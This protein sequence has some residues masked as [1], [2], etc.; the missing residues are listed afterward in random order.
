MTATDLKCTIA[1][2]AA[3][4]Q[5]GRSIAQTA[6]AGTIIYL[7]GELG[8][9]KTTFTRGFLRGLGYEGSVKS[10]TYTVVEPYELDKLTVYHFDLY[11]LTDPEE[12]ELIGM[13]DY[14]A[15]HAICIIEWP[16][17]GDSCLPA[18]DLICMIA[19]QQDQRA[20]TLLANSDIGKRI[21]RQL[22]EQDF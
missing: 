21:I 17:K 14:A 12:L 19:Y 7:Q 16:E 2:E 5:L 10:P 18:A 9:G 22:H 15:G 6:E 1:S 8:A 4:E 3:M 11:R 20:V 13:R